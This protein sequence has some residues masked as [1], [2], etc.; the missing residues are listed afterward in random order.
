MAYS[1]NFTK[2]VLQSVGVSGD[3]YHKIVH[4]TNIMTEEA[5]HKF[6]KKTGKFE[7][8]LVPAVAGTSIE[9]I[10]TNNLT[11]S[12]SATI[13]NFTTIG[14]DNQ[15]G[16]LTRH[17]VE[18]KKG[19]YMVNESCKLGAG[20]NFGAGNSVGKVI[21]VT[22]GSANRF[23]DTAGFSIKTIGNTFGADVNVGNEMGKFKFGA[24]TNGINCGVGFGNEHRN[25][26]IGGNSGGFNISFGFSM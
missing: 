20:Y 14:G 8:I 25:V 22:T 21:E 26:N 9:V 17:D 10:R 15:T 2:N 6:N 5:H 13:T 16:I 11:P 1:T 12:G 19:D 3:E 7:P 23:G 24:D 18:F 4:T